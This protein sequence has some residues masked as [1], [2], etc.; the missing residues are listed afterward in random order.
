MLMPG[1][2][3]LVA[4]L[5]SFLTCFCLAVTPA[6]AG[7]SGSAQQ[8][9]QDPIVVQRNRLLVEKYLEDASRLRAE[10][11][12]EEARSLLLHARDIMPSDERVNSALRS[13]AAETGERPGTVQ[14]YA[15]QMR[16]LYEIREQRA[17]AEAQALLEA[18]QRAAANHDYEAA[19]QSYRRVLL[20]IDVARD[21]AW[22]DLPDRA[23][24][25]M[26]EAEQQRDRRAREEQETAERET[27]RR[28]REVEEAEL[29][30]RRARVD[31][32]MATAIRAFQGG[33][34]Q[35][36]QDLA[37]RAL[38]IEPNNE[39]ARNLHN[40]ATKALRDTS[41][42]DYYRRKRDEFR[43]MMEASEELR[44]PYTDVLRVDPVVWERAGER[45]LGT[46]VEVT[47]SEDDR[48]VRQRIRTTMVPA[49]RFTEE[50]GT[51]DE[52]KALLTTL[53][54]V[55][56]II[57]PEARAAIAEESLTVRMDLVAELSVENFLTQMTSLS[58]NLAWT[59]RNGV[60]EITT[61]ALAGGDKVL[62]THDIR[63]LKFPLTNFT[64][65][66]IRD[67]PS[68]EAGPGPR[69]GGEEEDKVA[70]IEDDALRL[71]I[72]QATGPENWEG[73]APATLEIEGGYLLVTANPQLQQAV[74]K[75]LD[76]QRRFATAVVTVES[77]FLTVTQN[78]LQEIGTDFRGLG[79]S[80]N[81]GTNA[82]LDDVT[83]RLDDNASRGLDNGGTGEDAGHP[84]SGAFFNDGGD[85]DVR[86]R[87]ENFFSNGALGRAL[88]TVGGATAAITILDDLELQM[89]IRAVE[90]REN[91]EVVNSQTVTVLN[92]TRANVAVINQ[93]SYVRD[94]DVEVAQASF[95]ADPVVDV[96]QDGIVLDVRPVI[97][98]DRK[99]IK[100]NLQ[101]TVAELRRP[102]PTF[103]TS[104][105]GST[106]PVTLQLPVLTVKSF[107]TTA[108]I[109]DGGSVLIGG[110]REALTR[111]RRA[112]VPVLG[113][114][115]LI[116]FFFKQEGVADENNALMVLVRAT[117]TD[118]KDA[119][120]AR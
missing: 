94:F 66:T 31:G 1:R 104:L 81:K 106:L 64:P 71:Q 44:T 113:S 116:S 99:H 28:L 34:F 70:Y 91:I 103:T 74:E 47:E 111:E 59:V 85:G 45:A 58:P 79:G 93:T 42:D 87:T 105:A 17:V 15:E 12:T 82:T 73:D 80:G 48:A 41:R 57:T 69:T 26:R 119:T 100:M 16:R 95:I 112:E 60:V 101:P 10:G 97:S 77:K 33:R 78:F 49:R 3:P 89:I 50:N 14:T 90:K 88:S 6:T 117:I 76:D 56:I 46:R 25:L 30:Q 22:G 83:N 36:A 43:K 120:E 98:Y 107:S 115:P 108:E 84:S 109:P 2:D 20:Q 27:L 29:A 23:R 110:L 96:I 114:I 37:Y 67:L 61:K 72:Q 55:P 21:I 9:Q 62:R 38:A 4:L 65:P 53:S 52:V 13:L 102:I 5:A 63:D 8:G 75:F 7:S 51:F 32:Y 11:K 54:G 18:G 86:A 68:G 40:A 92:N 39:D 19:I 35:L 24:A 118:I